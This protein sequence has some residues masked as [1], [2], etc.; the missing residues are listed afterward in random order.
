MDQRH[1]IE[2]KTGRDVTDVMLK[3]HN[4]QAY[5]V[6]L[7]VPVQNG[8]LHMHFQYC[9]LTMAATCAGPLS[10]WDRNVSY[11]VILGFR[12]VFTSALFAPSMH[13]IAKP[14]LLPSPQDTLCLITVNILLAFII[15]QKYLWDQQ[16]HERRS[17]NTIFTVRRIQLSLSMS[18]W[19]CMT[20]RDVT[21]LVNLESLRSKHHLKICKL[22]S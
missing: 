21:S 15:L 6:F 18:S 9:G 1:V 4:S 17:P 22:I 20:H 8:T 12:R 2:P 16:I 10:P 14:T 5:L 11:L 7:T 3:G 13:T 19:Y